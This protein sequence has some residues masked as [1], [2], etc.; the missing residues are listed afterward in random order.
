MGVNGAKY[1]L[2]FHL[3]LLEIF[4]AWFVKLQF[5]S[6]PLTPI[7]L[8]SV[9]RVP[10][11]GMRWGV[12]EPFFTMNSRV[13]KQ[14][15]V[16]QSPRWSP[17]SDPS[18]GP[19]CRLQTNKMVEEYVGEGW[20]CVMTASCLLA[21]SIYTNIFHPLHIQTLQITYNSYFVYFWVSQPTMLV[22]G[23][24]NKT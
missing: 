22:S 6:A 9:S 19:S 8:L 7:H 13:A 1:Q 4:L 23:G 18:P 17:P 3:N 14:R 15:W 21:I 24:R 11:W 5:N 20:C 10:N 12:T 2:Y 16:W